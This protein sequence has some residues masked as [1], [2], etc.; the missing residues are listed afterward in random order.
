[1]KKLKIETENGT[2]LYICA[3]ATPWLHGVRKPLV[4]PFFQFPRPLHVDPGSLET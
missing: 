3:H 4:S 1:M 2:L